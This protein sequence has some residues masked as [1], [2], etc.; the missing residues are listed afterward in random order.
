ML[1]TCQED[2][3]DIGEDIFCALIGVIGLAEGQTLIDRAE[4]KLD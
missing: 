2:C 4:G 1:K 3:L